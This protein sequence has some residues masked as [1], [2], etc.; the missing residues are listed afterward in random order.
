MN[1]E[2][3]AHVAGW[4]KTLGCI[5]SCITVNLP[6]P[7]HIHRGTGKHGAKHTVFAPASCTAASRHVQRKYP[8]WSPMP[9]TPR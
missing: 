8:A 7:G 5:P 9:T 4:G 3:I 2:T 1:E 6:A